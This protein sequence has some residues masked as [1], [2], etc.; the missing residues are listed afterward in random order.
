MIK[1]TNNIFL[2]EAAQIEIDPVELLSN[3]FMVE[4][5]LED[6]TE[7][8]FEEVGEIRDAPEILTPTRDFFDLAGPL[9]Q[10]KQFATRPYEHRPQQADMAVNIALALQNRN[11]LCV[12][13]PTGIGKSFAYLVPIIHYAKTQA[14]PVVVSTETINLQ[15]QLIY[16]DIPFL[17]KIMGVEFKAALA[18]GRSNYL[19]LRRLHMATDEHYDQLLPMPSLVLDL[20]RLEQWVEN[21]CSGDRD[22]V[23]F[24]FDS[25]AWSYCCC[26]SGNCQGPQCEFFRNCFYWKARNSW[27]KA[28]VIIANHAMF[29]T[30]LKLKQDDNLEMTLL[31]KWSAVVIDEA[32]TLEDSAASHLGL[33]LSS[34][35]MMA[36]M[37]RLFN[38]DAGRGMLMRKGEAALSLRKIAAEIKPQI[39]AFFSMFENLLLERN[40]S[41]RRLH[42]PGMVPDLLSAGLSRLRNALADYAEEEED[43]SFKTELMAQVLRCDAFIDGIQSFIQMSFPDYVYWI[44]E[45]RNGVVLQGAPLNIPEIL[46]QVLFNRKFP[47]VLTSATLTVGRSFDYFRSRTGF[48]NGVEL[49]LDSPFSPDQVRLYIPR[50]MPEPNHEDYKSALVQNIPRFLD[51]THGKAFVLFTSYQLMRYCAEN[52]QSYFEKTGIRL[53]MQGEMS[54]SMLLQEFKDDIDSVIFGTDSFW[55]GV[56]VPGEALSNV[57]VTKFPFAVPSHPLIQARSERIEKSGK[58]SFMEYSMPEA[59]LKFRQGTGRLIRSKDD[60]GIIVIL[61]RRVISKRYGQKFIESMPPYPIEYVN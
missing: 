32:H 35:G 5:D 16:K 6:S 60:T 21:S 55:T 40:D 38:P 18:K 15:E 42:Q 14:C 19:C 59:A 57:I 12:E 56:D 7:E 2:Y 10:T 34:N 61:D 46:E 31:P 13:A 52:L 39:G 58:N 49:R 50:S 1:P 17:Q 20:Q 30:D 45:E 48:T 33:R 44:E 41:V 51:V 47:V 36:F 9:A 53:L 29:F 22:D 23:K 25:S 11:N 28:D 8:F 4:Y 24:R 54:R 27:E 37:N 3:E 43:K 26:E